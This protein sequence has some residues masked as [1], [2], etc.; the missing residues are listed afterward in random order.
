MTPS[1]FLDS[2]SFGPSI[3][4]PFACKFNEGSNYDT[5]VPQG[6]DNFFP[7]KIDIKP[8]LI[9]GKMKF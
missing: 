9:D 4:L 7:E 1:Q 3:A 8:Q 2:L 5:Y 6:Q